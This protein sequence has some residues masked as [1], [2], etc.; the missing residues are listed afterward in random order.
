VSSERPTKASFPAPL[1]A[2]V[3]ANAARAF[4]ERL[5]PLKLMP[6]HAGILHRLGRSSGLSQRELAT[7]LGMYASRLVGILDE[8]ESLGL[9]VRE[10]NPD[11]RRTYSLMLTPKGRERLEEVSRISWQHNEAVCAALNEQERKSLSE[12]LQRI[13]DQQGL[14]RG[15]HPGFSRLGA[16]TSRESLESRKTEKEP[17]TVD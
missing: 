8:M 7:Q 2:Q 9:V 4:A 10:A 12:L 16:N 1:L 3:G 5:E 13:A 6:A 14:I 11:D 15:V 17:E